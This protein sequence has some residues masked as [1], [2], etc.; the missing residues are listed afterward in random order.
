M[1]RGAHESGSLSFLIHQPCNVSSLQ[2]GSETLI[3]VYRLELCHPGLHKIH[4]NAIVNKAFS[5]DWSYWLWHR[6][7]YIC[8]EISKPYALSHVPMFLLNARGNLE[9]QAKKKR[10]S[11]QHSGPKT[12][13][14]HIKQAS[15]SLAFGCSCLNIASATS[16]RCTLPVAVLGIKSVKNTCKSLVIFYVGCE[17]LSRIPSW[18][19]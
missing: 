9:I 5:R 13:Y 17:S 18:E 14:M 10:F 2:Y 15:Y 7:A 4:D 11:F 12:V 8:I 1:G 16:L 19:A 3:I 6:Q